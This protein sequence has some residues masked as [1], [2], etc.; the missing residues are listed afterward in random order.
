MRTITW[1]GTITAL[2]SIAHGEETRGTTT[3]LRRELVTT[4]NDDRV[5][6][7]VISGNTLRGRLRPAPSDAS[8]Q[9]EV[10]GWGCRAGPEDDGGDRHREGALQPVAEPQREA[11]EPRDA[12]GEEDEE[13][14]RSPPHGAAGSVGSGHGRGACGGGHAP[15]LGNG[16]VAPRRPE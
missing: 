2:S 11:D 12:E 7:P 10:R 8:R 9:A 5:L 1:T 15:T 3:L 6:V 14:H 13:G 16:A 4:P